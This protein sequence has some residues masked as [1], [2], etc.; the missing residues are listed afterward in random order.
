MG[1][2]HLINRCFP[3]QLCDTPPTHS[4]P[5]SVPQQF[6]CMYGFTWAPQC[7]GFLLYSANGRLQKEMEGRGEGQVFIVSSSTPSLLDADFGS[8]CVL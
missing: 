4:L 6:D 3:H 8:G 5:S 1:Q 2:R 7:F